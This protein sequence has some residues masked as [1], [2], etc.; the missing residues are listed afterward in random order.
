MFSEL[1]FA[2]PARISMRFPRKTSECQR[3]LVRSSRIYKII[4]K[5]HLQ[6]QKIKPDKIK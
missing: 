2:T 5:I 3:I 1:Q 4:F 6:Q